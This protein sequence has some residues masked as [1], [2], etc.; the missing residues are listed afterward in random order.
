MLSGACVLQLEKSRHHNKDPVQ[1]K[2][3]KNPQV[4]ALSAPCPLPY[5][6]E[7]HRRPEKGLFFAV[8]R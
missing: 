5:G 4:E 6:T 8:E 1:P 7:W 3:I 2:K